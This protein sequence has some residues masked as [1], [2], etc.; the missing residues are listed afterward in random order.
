MTEHEFDH[1]AKEMKAIVRPELVLIAEV[2]GEPVAFSMTLPD[3]NDALKAAEG[4]LDDLRAAHRAGEAAARLAADPPAAA[5]HARRSRRGSGKRG[6]DAILYLD[7][8]THARRSSATPAARSPGR[9]RTI[10]WSTGRSRSMG[11]KSRPTDLRARDLAGGQSAGPPHRRHRLH[12]RTAG[13]RR[14]SSAATACT[15]LVRRTSKRGRAGGA[16]RRIRGGRS[17]H[18]RGAAEA[19]KGVDCVVAPR[20][21]HQGPLR[22]GL[23]P[24]QRRGTRRLASVLARQK[25]PTPA[26]GLQLARRRRSGAASAGPH[27]GGARAPVSMYGR[28][29]LGGEQAVREFADQVPT[30]I[31]RPPIV[32]GPGDL[33]QVPPLIAMGKTGVYL[34]AGMGPKHFSFVHVDD[35]NQALIAAAERG[36]TLSRD[37]SDATAST[38]PRTRPRTAQEDSASSS[39]ARWDGASRRSSRCP[40][41]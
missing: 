2:K 4:R 39:A 35:L 11:G 10:T 9:S 13:E 12:R 34:K 26:G 30:V 20:R 40:R 31:V 8:L 25:R 41:S 29:K 3:A 19:A 18:R 14:S 17:P 28:S 16:R 37:E 21:R 32:Y 27:R 36:K 23:P 24:G 38:S 1:M 15:A 33:D 22:G 7:T 6:I 5:D